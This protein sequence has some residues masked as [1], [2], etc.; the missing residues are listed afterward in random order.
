MLAQV[1]QTRGVGYKPV[2]SRKHIEGVLQ[3]C[4]CGD[5]SI[6]VPPFQDKSDKMR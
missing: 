3:V 6:G 2:F 4:E 5:A 1:A